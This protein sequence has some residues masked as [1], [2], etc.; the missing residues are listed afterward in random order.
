[1][2]RIQVIGFALLCFAATGCVE[3]ET[4]YTVNPDGSAKVHIDVITSAQTGFVAQSSPKKPDEETLDDLLRKGI[5]ATLEMKNV[6]AWKD[7]SA[8]FLPNGKLKFVGTAYVKH[9]RDFGSSSGGILI[10]SPT[11]T[12]SNQPDGSM[13]LTVKKDK[14][15]AQAAMSKRKPK[16]PAEIK[17]MSDEELDRHILRDLIDLQSAR[18]LFLAMLTNGKVKTTYVLPGDV[19]AATQ[20]TRDESKA[21]LAH[22]TVDGNKYVANLDRFLAMSP[23]E[24]RKFYRDAATALSLETFLFLGSDPDQASIQV[25]PPGAPLFDFDKEVAEAHAAYPALR[26]KFGFGEDLR[27]PTG[28]MPPKK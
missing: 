19:T 9:L 20:F 27:L 22:F 21:N 23:A 8:E 7:V 13:L 24:H 2:K 17:G 15:D 18:P 3:G 25:A 12:V 4:T 6:V 11:C 10:L 16:M 14:K 28:E 5:R 1:M 26:K